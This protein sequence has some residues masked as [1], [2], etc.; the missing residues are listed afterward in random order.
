M[1]TVGQ[2]RERD[3]ANIRVSEPQ[4][5]KYEEDEPRLRVTVLL[6]APSS[7]SNTFI[8]G[9][10][11]ICV[12]ISQVKGFFFAHIYCIVSKIQASLPVEFWNLW[13]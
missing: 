11:L 5:E 8:G 12:S 4:R 6:A 1:Q 7:K 9:Q 13:H 2:R 10:F 3:N